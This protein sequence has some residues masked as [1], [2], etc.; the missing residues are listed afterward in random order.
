LGLGWLLRAS[1]PRRLREPNGGQPM[2]RD[3]SEVKCGALRGSFAA[4][5]RAAI[6]ARRIAIETDTG[7]VIVRDGKIVHISAAE[8]REGKG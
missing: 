7:I 6:E 3:I 4:L 1:L 2:T 8:L 5:K